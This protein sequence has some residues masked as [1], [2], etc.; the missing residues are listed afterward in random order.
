MRA[1]RFIPLAFVADVHGFILLAPYLVI[2]L[3]V[4]RTV[5]MY[6]TPSGNVK[7]VRE[8]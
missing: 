3:T 5:Q 6:G 2:F 8:T 7:P 4:V 1:A